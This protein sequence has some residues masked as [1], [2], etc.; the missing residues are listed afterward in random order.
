MQTPIQNF[1]LCYRFDLEDFSYNQVNMTSFRLVDTAS[2]GVS[3]ALRAMETASPMSRAILNRSQV[4][5]TEPALVYDSVMVFAKGLERALA[6][7]PE[8]FLRFVEILGFF[9]FARWE[10]GRVRSKDST[11]V[12]SDQLV[13]AVADG[14]TKSDC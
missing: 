4:I 1:P 13:E 3:S 6:E 11:G 14:W 2:E 12:E 5:L 10:S 7:G 9:V 8:L